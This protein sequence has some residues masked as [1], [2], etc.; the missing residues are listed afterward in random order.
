MN[1]WIIDMYD[2]GQTLQS[3]NPDP[4]VTDRNIILG[5][6][7]FLRYPDRL[8]LF[9]NLTRDQGA[10]K[11]P[12]WQFIVYWF[13]QSLQ[14]SYFRFELNTSDEFINIFTKLYTLIIVAALRL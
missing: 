1:K 14:V 7:S 12:G 9:D 10:Y 2:M 5:R 11:H 6:G 13:S 8:D 4:V 3:R